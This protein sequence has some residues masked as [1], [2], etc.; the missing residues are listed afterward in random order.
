MGHPV[1]KGKPILNILKK[2][3]F[4]NFQPYEL[5]MSVTSKK[6]KKNTVTNNV[7]ST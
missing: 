5:S 1:Y 2:R 6:A 3:D 4:F 7:Q